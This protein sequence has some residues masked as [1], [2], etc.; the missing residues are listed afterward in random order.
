MEEEYRAQADIEGVIGA[1]EGLDGST[2]AAHGPGEGEDD[3]Y[4]STVSP[5]PSGSGFNIEKRISRFVE[6]RFP[7]PSFITIC[8]ILASIY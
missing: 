1:G 6:S 8:N 3:D 4:A 2:L 7:S 5:H